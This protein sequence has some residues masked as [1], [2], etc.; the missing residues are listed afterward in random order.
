MAPSGSAVF[1][2]SGSGAGSTAGVL[3]IGSGALGGWAATNHSGNNGTNSTGYCVTVYK[4]TN[5]TDGKNP[6]I[7][8]LDGANYSFVDG[9]V[10]WMY[11]RGI[12]NGCTAPD[13]GSAT[14]AIDDTKGQ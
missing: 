3:A 10:K 4:G 12:G 13:G 11:N 1:T 5:R 2:S 14:F 9:H 7:R 6:S 8:H